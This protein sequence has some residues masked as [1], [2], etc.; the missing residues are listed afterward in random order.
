MKFGVPHRCCIS[1]QKLLNIFIPT[2]LNYKK[3]HQITLSG[4]F[5]EK[6]NKNNLLKSNFE[7]TQSIFATLKILEF[8]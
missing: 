2:S 7:L 6:N 5:I 4:L 1:C 3:N 8:Y